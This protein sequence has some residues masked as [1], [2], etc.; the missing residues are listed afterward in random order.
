[1][2]TKT[3]KYCGI[4]KPLNKFN[5]N[6]WCNDC[7]KAY[8]KNYKSKR[9]DFSQTILSDE[10]MHQEM[11]SAKKIDPKGLNALADLTLQ[12]EKA[13][14][15]IKSFNSAANKRSANPNSKKAILYNQ[16]NFTN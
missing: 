13:A 12:F 3:C 16:H 10:D 14:K 6:G 4:N 9:L 7:M 5:S 15:Q 11:K 8:L 1:M 2:T